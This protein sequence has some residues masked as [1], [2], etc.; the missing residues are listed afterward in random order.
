MAVPGFINIGTTRINN[1]SSNSSTNFSK[2]IHN[3]HTAHTK[4]TG[5]NRTYGNISFSSAR[6][7]NI[8]L[9]LDIND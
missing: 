8:H 2:V 9:D 5:I 6:M 1:T 3:S 4:S 7:K